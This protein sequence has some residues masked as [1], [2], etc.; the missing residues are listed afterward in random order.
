MDA[1]KIKFWI[2]Q[3]EARG[4]S[5]DELE[6]KLIEAGHSKS[7]IDAVLSEMNST[8][9]STKKTSTTTTSSKN[10]VKDDISE[11]SGSSSN[12]DVH[13]KHRNPFLVLLF[14]L[15]TFGI[16]GIVW[17]VKTTNELSSVPGS[18]NPKLLWLWIILPIA[19][20]VSIYIIWKNT[21]SITKLTGGNH[22]MLFV[23]WLLV[24]PVGIILFQ[25]EMNKKA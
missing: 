2:K 22:I 17:M 11:L 13:I 3:G 1:D 21:E 10:D 12:A 6:Q 9:S 23:L 16:Y 24:A 8:G 20:F 18:A 25:M 5:D 15:I 7:E 14:A 4:Y 19:G